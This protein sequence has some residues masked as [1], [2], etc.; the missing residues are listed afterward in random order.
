MQSDNEQPTEN[1]QEITEIFTLLSSLRNGDEDFGK[2][3]SDKLENMLQMPSF[4]INEKRYGYT[5]LHMAL[6]VAQTTNYSPN[7]HHLV[8]FVKLLLVN[9][10]DP[11]IHSY[12]LIL[13]AFRIGK[14]MVELFIHTDV[15]FSFKD[16]YNSVQFS[17]DYNIILGIVKRDNH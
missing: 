7:Y 14:E 17:L 6:K 5:M 10:A 4:D 12:N 8:D 9:G 11:V 13:T 15:D 1:D 2:G 16:R 3:L